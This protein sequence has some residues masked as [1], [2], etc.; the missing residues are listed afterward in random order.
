MGRTARDDRGCAAVRLPR[1]DARRGPALLPRRRRQGLHRPRQRA[2]FNHL[3]LHLTDDQGWRLQIDSWPRLTERAAASSVGG[4]SGG[5]Y[6]KDDYREILAHAAA[7]HITVVPE[8]DLPG[9]THAV[10]VA[11]PELVEEPVLSED[12]VRSAEALG[13]ALPAAGEPYTGWGVGHSSLR[14]RTA[15]T[16]RFVRDVL[17]ELAELTPGPWLHIGGD[18]AF[19]TDPADFASFMARTTALVVELGKTPVAWHEAGSGPDIAPGTVGQYWGSRTPQGAHAAE[20]SRFV[21]RGGRLI[22]SPSDAAYL[23]MKYDEQFPLG[24]SWAGVVDVRTAYDWEP[25]AILPLP[26]ASVLGVEAPLWT[27]TVRDLRDADRLVF[28][29]VAAIAEIAWS[30]AAAT[31]RTWESFRERVGRLAPLWQSEG[32]DHHAAEEIPWSSR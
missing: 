21:E 6:T 7:R 9:H 17:S 10:G 28:P 4:E 18:E 5:F 27:E 20:A 32:I 25:T 22:M 1:R 15:D 14:I 31:E 30:P 19:G 8:I 23:D 12:L 3:H 24:L 11:Y 13:Q 16:E 29:R 2:K 26:A